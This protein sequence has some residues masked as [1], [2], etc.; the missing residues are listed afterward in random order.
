MLSFFRKSKQDEPAPKK[1][2]A[3][4]KPAPITDPKLAPPPAAPAPAVAPQVQPGTNEEVVVFESISAD[5]CSVVEEAAVYYAN[6]L[7]DQAVMVLNQYVHEHP[8]KKEMQPWL[9]LF[10]LYQL[11]NNKQAFNEL[12]MQFVVKFERSAPIWKTPTTPAPAKKLDPVRKDLITLGSNLAAGPELEK[13]CQL[14]KSTDNARLDVGNIATVDLGGCKLM[15]EG[16]LGCRKK[17]QLVQLE[18][19]D[20]LVAVLKKQISSDRHG[21]EDRLAWLLL[22][23]IY[24][25]LGKEAEYED[26]AIEYAVTF[27]ISPPAWEAVKP[28]LTAAQTK[29]KAPLAAAEPVE[30]DAFPLHGVISESSQAQ[31]QA[32]SNF[33][34]DKQEVRINMAQVTRVD[35]VAVGNFMGTL[36]SLTQAG[37]KVL[38]FE[39]NELIQALFNVM[40][41]SEFA[42][43]MRKKTR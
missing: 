24:Q 17:G 42:T 18:G 2:A 40:G 32:L 8:E 10:D 43:L 12:S 35:F 14:A 4:D 34:A 20:R 9:M 3:A 33:A 26:L 7:A 13:I 21:D 28:A 23:E 39:A 19:V 6:N 29:P 11:L 27:E 5:A 16:L 36:I 41:V 22:F 25:W 31:L 15:Q 30:E 38:L 1:P 37:K